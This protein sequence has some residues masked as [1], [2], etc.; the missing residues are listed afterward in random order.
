MQA[1]EGIKI[2]DFSKWLPGQY[3]GM[4]LGDFGADVIKVEDVKGD[5][6]RGFTPAKEPGM[7]YWHL[8]LNRNKRGITVNLK[9]PAGR[10]VL[11][12]LLKD[13]DVFLEGFRPGY[14]KMLGLDYESVSK[15]NPRLIYCSITG[16][17]PEG[18][19]K[20]MPSHDL[21]V[22]GLAG[23][24]A[25]EDGTDISVPSVQVA[26]LGGSL[27]AISGILMALY[28]RERT[29]KG[30]LVNV[31]L[32]S[33]AIN[34]EITAISSVIGCRETGMPSFGRTAS[35]YYSVYKTKDGRYLSIGTIEPKFWQKCCRLIDLPELESRQFDFANS[36]EIKEKLAAAFAGKT[37]AE[38]LELIGKD[39]FCV[40]PIRTL[41]EALDSSLTTEQSQMLVTKKEDFGNY[42]YVKSAAKLSD[43]PHYPQT[44]ALFGRA[45]AG[46]AGKRGLY[47]RRN[48][49]H[50]RKR[51]DINGIKKHF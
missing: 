12:R 14:L 11:L 32:Y 36:A 39:E 43:T 17:G 23:V 9:T 3:C 6:T 5:V 38:W 41:Q 24:A 46:S 47:Q 37:Q 45:Y 50:A 10:E 7:S 21:N 35:H 26:A 31:D 20:H 33:S 48:C 44:R 8:M 42:T 51:G 30:Q 4:V 22:I 18:K 16:F 29:G 2:I 28:A 34:A 19:Y 25:P 15:I 13:A 27:N 40:T 49:C 1:L